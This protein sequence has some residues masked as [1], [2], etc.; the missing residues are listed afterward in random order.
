MNRMSSTPIFDEVVAAQPKGMWL[1]SR[2]FDP[3][4][5]QSTCPFDGYN[6]QICIC[7]HWDTAT[8][9]ILP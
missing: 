3:P 4:P 5:H 6:W 8:G 2:I 7:G 9:R 1:V